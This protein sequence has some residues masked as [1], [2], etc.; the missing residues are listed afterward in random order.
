[1]PSP[2]NRVKLVNCPRLKLGFTV[3]ALLTLAL[4]QN[5]AA[6]C[7]G[8]TEVCS[9]PVLSPGQVFNVS[10]TVTN[11]G[12]TTVT[13]IILY[14]FTTDGSATGA[15]TNQ[16]LN[17]GTLQA[18]GSSNYNF[19]IDFSAT[20]GCGTDID[21]IV[22]SGTADTSQT[23]TA[24]A[25]CTNI[26][27]NA[28]CLAVTETCSRTNSGQVINF[29]G[30]VTNCGCAVL[31]N[32]TLVANTPVG[33]FQIFTIPWLP[34]GA[35]SNYNANIVATNLDCTNYITVFASGSVS[36]TTQS[37]SFSTNCLFLAQSQLTLSVP[38]PFSVLDADGVRVEYT[39]KVSGGV[40]PYTNFFN[41][42][43]GF[44]T[45]VESS[46]GIARVCRLYGT[47][48]DVPAGFN[49]TVTD[50]CGNNGGQGGSLTPPCAVCLSVGLPSVLTGTNGSGIGVTLTNSPCGQLFGTNSRWFRMA[51]TNSVDT[52]GLFTTKGPGT[53][54]VTTAGSD[55]ATILAVYAGPI[56]NLVPVACNSGLS[57]NHQSQVQLSV[58]PNTNYWVVVNVTNGGTLHLTSYFIQRAPTLAQWNF[59]TN[60]FPNSPAPSVGS[61]A[62]ALIGGTMS[63]FVS[64]SGSSDTN[65]TN[66]A[67]S[68]TNYPSPSAG[69]K[70]RGVQFNVSTL[71]YQYIG[72]SWDQLVSSNA[73]KYFRLQ[74][75]TNGTTFNDFA[76]PEVMT[77]NGMFESKYFDFSSLPGVNNNSN[78]AVRI[79][80]EFASTATGTG[81][82]N[83]VTPDGVASY[84]TNGSVVFD[85][86]TVVGT[87]IPRLINPTF[88][89]N[90]F[91]FS[92]V[93]AAGQQVVLQASSNLTSWL[94]VFTIMLPYYP[95]SEFNASSYQNRFYRVLCQP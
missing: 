27:Q 13:N 72:V 17:L 38:S 24:W 18:G 30:A 62:A 20:P 23:V 1:M 39:I 60:S 12:M 69:N 52:N 11:C 28:P 37:V 21:Y 41:F 79:L 95:Y 82:S 15:G 44:T 31:T 22:V 5:H 51:A 57:N 68:T 59:D 47:F 10:G 35:S 33:L 45:N 85:M 54:L 8:V 6:P 46:S 43:D 94:P 75:T 7:L 84:S 25:A 77:A 56:T 9:P 29:R 88:G 36:G 76:Y 74:T 65:A 93:G 91:N 89:Y 86:F 83:Y 50:K 40:V 3:S 53:A 66:Y 2:K 34:P 55:Y 87:P 63:T 14:S 16:I 81:S 90:A 26:V 71:G 49:F 67:W 58:Q 80:S 4:L 48:D 70:T 73:S 19:S 42:S 64:G 61:G 78:F 92:V 32:V